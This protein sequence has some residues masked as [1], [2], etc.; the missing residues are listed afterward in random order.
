MTDYPWLKKPT[1]NR[2]VNWGI[3]L[4]FRHGYNDTTNAFKAYR[5]E[6]IDNIKPFLSH[7]FNL[8]VEL[9]LKAVVRGYSYG[10]VP[11]SWTNRKA[12]VSKLSLNE[13]GS[14]YLFIV[15]YV[16]L[17][18]HLSRGDYRRD[19]ANCRNVLGESGEPDASNR[20]SSARKWSP[21]STRAGNV[22]GLPTADVA[23]VNWNTAEAALRAEGAIRRS[24]G[25]RVRLTVVDNLSRP[26][27]RALLKERCDPS[28]RLILAKRNLGYGTA[29]NLALKGGDGEVVC[30]CNADI[31]PQADAL[32]HL[33]EV[34]L[35]DPLVGMVGPV[36]EGGPSITTPDF[37][38]AS[39]CW[40]DRW[41]APFGTRR[42]PTPAPGLTA[43]IEQVSGA[44]FVLRRKL[45]E[46]IGGFDEGFFLWYDD[47]DLARRLVDAGYHNLI[48]G[49]AR[50]EHAGAGSFSQFERS[51][52]QATRLS[53]LERYI[54]KHHARL[55][56][57]ARPVLA[58]GRR[59]RAR[60]ARGTRP[61]P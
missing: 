59:V 40:A 48:V 43:E 15:L 14:R 51:T 21:E 28:T 46:E 7:H 12:G 3:R 10:I 25:V 17:E 42:P 9:P 19:G 5:R 22:A 29:A 49:S 61:A 39:H 30:V 27:Q 38:A 41:S 2:I 1:M 53:S 56:P 23:I 32:A 44:C 13:M 47:V 8:T 4:L 26:E 31:L 54:S 52:A 58:V 6:V 45:W 11:I 57:A 35:G 55:L 20:G 18:H 37:R 34:V 60:S 16:F 24:E 50:V 36:F 33:T